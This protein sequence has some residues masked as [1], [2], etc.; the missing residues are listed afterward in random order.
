MESNIRFDLEG[1]SEVR[2]GK[3]IDLRKKLDLHTNDRG[4]EVYL[5]P[6]R[7]TEDNQE[8]WG[9]SYKQCQ[10]V[11]YGGRK[12]YVIYVETHDRHQAEEA[13]KDLDNEM[14]R[15]YL[16]NRCPIVTEN[17][18]IRCPDGCKCGTKSCP[19]RNESIDRVSMFA[20]LSSFAAPECDEDERLDDYSWL[21]SDAFITEKASDL[22][23]V[24]DESP[25]EPSLVKDPTADEAIRNIEEE[26]I[27]NFLDGINPKCRMVYE[28]RH[29]GWKAQEIADYIGESVDNVNYYIRT[30]KTLMQKLRSLRA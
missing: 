14:R 5:I 17:G 2:I 22:P 1:I 4:E 18:I 13:W 30:I 23:S 19:R 7:I 26:E 28:K 6:H 24:Y 21:G 8:A 11:P 12:A 20:P 10:A 29:L 25:A 3:R 15:E 16:E 9:V 27:L